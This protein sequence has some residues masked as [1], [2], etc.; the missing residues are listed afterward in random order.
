MGTT[1]SVGDLRWVDEF[2]NNHSSQHSLL[3]CI[4][5]KICRLI[6]DVTQ[7]TINFMEGGLVTAELELV[8]TRS[9]VSYA[10]RSSQWCRTRGLQGV[11][12]EDTNQNLNAGGVQP[13]NYTLPPTMEV[14][15]GPIVQE[16]SLVGTKIIFLSSMIVGG[17]AWKSNQFIYNQ[18]PVSKPHKTS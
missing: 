2:C 8:R 3:D 12:V 10:T 16:T 4:D 14:E 15:N 13:L 1:N 6:F 11:D 9:D 7:V 18:N 5:W 17:R